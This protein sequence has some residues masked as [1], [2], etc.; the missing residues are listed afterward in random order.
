VDEPSV[1]ELD[2]DDKEPKDV[3]DPDE[4]EEDGFPIIVWKCDG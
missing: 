2:V 4:G 1:K 3:E